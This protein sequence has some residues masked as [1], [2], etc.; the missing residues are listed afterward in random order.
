MRDI[1]SILPTPE[2]QGLYYR[3]DLEFSFYL[4]E[5]ARLQA[6][7]RDNIPRETLV[8][9]YQEILKLGWNKEAFLE[10][11]EAV[12]RVKIYKAI[13]FTH[14]L[15]AEKLYTEMEL[16]KIVQDRIDA[17]VR[18]GIKIIKATG[19]EIKIT[20]SIQVS[21]NELE[22]IRATVLKIVGTYYQRER[23]FIT[24][25]VINRIMDKIKGEDGLK[26]EFSVYIPEI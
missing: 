7:R 2:L 26:N 11:V 4:A 17:I 3:G 21:E 9:W 23:D 18:K 14:F 10:R 13:D 20:G 24:R 1:A 15:E 6:L 25:D 5:I 19:A 16:N 8:V 12:K 22:A